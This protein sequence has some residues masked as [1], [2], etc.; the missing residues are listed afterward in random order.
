MKIPCNLEAMIF[1]TLLYTLLLQAATTQSLIAQTRELQHAWEVDPDLGDIWKMHEPPGFAPVQLSLLDAPSVEERLNGA[2]V[3]IRAAVDPKFTKRAQALEKLLEAVK[4]PESN[5]QYRRVMMSAILALAEPTQA[6]QLWEI[7]KADSILRP[8]VE[9]VF[10]KWRSA[11][12]LPEWRQRIDDAQATPNEVALALEGLA[13]VGTP[14]DAA[15]LTKLLTAQD[16]G[17]AT[18]LLASKALGTTN[19]AGLNA[20][21]QQV[22]NSGIP[23]ADI[24]S[25]NLLQKH[26]GEV[27]KEHLLAI[28]GEGSPAAQSIA[29]MRLAEF[30]PLTAKP[31]A[32]KMLDDGDSTTKL[33][34]IKLLLQFDDEE[35]VRTASQSM[36]DRHPL[37]RQSARELLEQ[38]AKQSNLRPI[39]DEQ[40]S[41]QI[42]SENINAL[43]QSTVL[44]V[45]LQ[46]KRH[47]V[48][49][50]ELLSHP[51]SQVNVRA[52]WSLMELGDAAEVQ[53]RLLEFA[54]KEA[55]RFAD[56]E[57][58]IG[59]SEFVRASYL[60]E[61]FG[62]FQNSAA[63]PLLRKFVPK[64]SLMGH[65]S[66]S[67]AIWSL[68]KL[69]SQKDVSDLRHELHARLS[70]RSIVDPE[71]YLV[72][73]ASALA[74][75]NMAQADSREPLT[76]NQDGPGTA[77]T[78]GCVWALEQIDKAGR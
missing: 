7:A 39:I 28:C 73:F 33:A 13:V 41:L 69:H 17:I 65:L 75:G 54:E 56:P 19:Q 51:A 32:A 42:H 68:G 77:L 76:T 52:A 48:R 5:P 6:D 36:G 22:L 34:V 29:F 23:Q 2:R 61:S 8:L 60:M 53:T 30:D 78:K 44:A 37:V 16:S 3:I 40:L 1:G 27:T 46:D 59:F 58:Q 43:E 47:C 10:I 70:D 45:S 38:K 9:R 55:N 35:S 11:I 31:L 21:A 15:R 71:D 66:R 18:Q 63:I 67:S 4:K 12:A 64:N 26:S 62:K 24:L 72:R 20:L 74:M 25:A 14:D 50:I 57:I 49:L